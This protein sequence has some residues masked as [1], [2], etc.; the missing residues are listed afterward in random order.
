MSMKFR[1]KN[2]M[3]RGVKHHKLVE[4]SGVRSEKELPLEYVNSGLRI[5]AYCGDIILHQPDC[6]Y[7]KLEI[8]MELPVERT[9]KILHDIA[10]AGKRLAKINRRIK[11]EARNWEDREWEVKI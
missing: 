10:T 2:T 8:G 3:V 7:C 6:R 11:E 4:M 9:G 5:Y 1:F